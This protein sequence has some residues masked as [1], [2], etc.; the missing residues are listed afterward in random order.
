MASSPDL[1]PLAARLSQPDLQRLLARLVARLRRG[2]RLNGRLR[3]AG[4]DVA[5]RRAI[6]SLLGQPVGSADNV[7][8]DLDLL[9]ALATRSGR[10]QSLDQLVQAAHGSQVVNE[11]A[12]RQLRD[13]AWRDFWGAAVQRVGDRPALQ[14]WVSDPATRRRFRRR[15]RGDLSAAGRLLDDVLQVLARLPAD[16][17]LS[18]AQLAAELLGDSHALDLETDLS[19][20]ALDGV[21]AIARCDRPRGARNIRATWAAAGVVLNELVATVLVL[22]L[23]ALR[24]TPLG[25]LLA[26]GRSNGE[27]CR[28]TFRQLRDAAA[29]QF[30]DSGGSE[31]FVCENPNVVAAAAERWG[32]RCRP[33]VC[34]EGQ[35]N[36]AA[37]ELL[38]VL[39]CRGFTPQYHGDFDWG[40]LRIAARLWNRF[41]LSP[42]RFQTDDYLSAPPGRPLRGR[43]VDAPWDPR[44]RSAMESRGAVVH[45]EAVMNRLLDDLPTLGEREG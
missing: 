30:D 20:A 41:H 15:A 28:L 39:V 25:D 5:E 33:L 32:R 21:A 7:S 45:E 1:D 40:G 2:R 44:L 9:A 16:P 26:L 13:S 37:E 22:N 4:V 8:V 18:L 3:L 19:R 11:S 36:L 14:R 34:M 23:P 27:P 17:P 42:W 12:R 6:A 31:L 35:P 29:C 10:F 38:R 24:G 43:A